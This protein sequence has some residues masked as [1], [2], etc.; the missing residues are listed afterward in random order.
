[1][2][3]AP[4][5]VVQTSAFSRLTT[6]ALAA[7]RS[8][9]LVYLG[10]AVL[11]RV[12]SVVLVPLYVRVLTREEY[13]EV[14]I[15]NSTILT[16]SSVLALGSQ[17]A[18]SRMYFDG[19]AGEA[20]S[21]RAGSVARWTLTIG[22]A[23]ALL[24]IPVIPF[25]SSTSFVWRSPLGLSCALLGA[26]GAVLISVPSNY[27][28]AAQLPYRAAAIDLLT[29]SATLLPALI[30]VGGFKMGLRGAVLGLGVGGGL[31]TVGA[32]VMILRWPGATWDTSLLPGILRFSLPIMPH[33]L[34]AQLLGV[35]DR[36]VLAGFGATASL[37]SISLA[38]QVTSPAGMVVS[39]RNELESARLGEALRSGG[40]P[41]L[42]DALPRSVRIYVA[43]AGLAS[44]GT[45]ALLPII[46]FV[47]GPKFSGALWI[48][49]AL[50]ACTM[51]D[52]F[53]LPANAVLVYTDRTRELPPITLVSGLVGLGANIFLIPRLGTWGV[54]L[55]RAITV[56]VRSTLTSLRAMV[57]LRA[58]D[59]AEAA[60][61]AA[62]ADH[63]QNA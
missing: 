63:D 1:M 34:A 9:A 27:F 24:L 19:E 13:G 38:S 43:A 60:A 7:L 14:A 22:V 17:A 39:A 5:A 16:L 25:V 48:V 44:L 57:A 40:R 6:R 45:I 21:R 56:T 2:S 54:V 37:G 49:P 11:A 10:A 35:G 12:A 32:A 30:M 51:I 8:P 36:W 41:G 47:V 62:V 28:R 15:V 61:A 31:C 58:V 52:V 55:A 33:L 20:A 26:L 23:M 53:Y 18:V 3:E 59:R 50:L 4:A 46:V 29:F 42:R